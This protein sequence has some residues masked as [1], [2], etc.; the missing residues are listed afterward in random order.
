M[1]VPSDPI[2]PSHLTSDQRLDEVAQILAT[3][4]RRLVS[5]RLSAPPESSGICLRCPS[6]PAPAPTAEA[7]APEWAARMHRRQDAAAAAA[8]PSSYG[9]G[10]R[11]RHR[12]V[13]YATQRA[14][15]TLS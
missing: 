10:R 12:E 5:L 1:A 3:G 6:P 7:T 14:G 13:N 15:D 9:S 11:P 2:D 8:R 4:V